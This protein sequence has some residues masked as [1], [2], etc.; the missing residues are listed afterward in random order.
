MKCSICKNE[1][2]G[3]VI[4]EDSPKVIVA[5]SGINET[6]LKYVIEEI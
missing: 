6:I 5:T 4:F 3:Y 2:S 1:I